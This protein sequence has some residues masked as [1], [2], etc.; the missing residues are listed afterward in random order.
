MVDLAPEIGGCIASFRT[1]RAGSIVNLMR[2]MSEE[3]KASRNAG[4]AA[5]FP[6]VP[7]ANRIAGNHF[8]FHGHTYQFKQNVPEEPFTIHGTGWQSAWTVATAN[9]TSAELNLDHLASNEPHSYSAVQRFRLTPDR[10]VVMTG[11][12]NRGDRTMP[13]GFGQHPCWERQAGVTLRFRSTHFW[14]SGAAGVPTERIATP[15]E[16]DFSQARP[17]PLAWRD[18]CYAGWDGRAEITFPHSGIG[19]HIDASSLFR[20]LMFY[21]DPAKTFFC[22]E[23][24]THATGALN[25]VA[26]NDEDHLGVLLLE[27]GESAEAEISFIQFQI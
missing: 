6:M 13:F 1:H 9:A 18:N 21:C 8:D 23:P 27:P 26:H 12:T 22:V 15:P 3:A 2:P 25:R 7:Y 17:L 11:V 20:H 10:L 5:M 16:L 4:G 24:Q 19:L 14:L